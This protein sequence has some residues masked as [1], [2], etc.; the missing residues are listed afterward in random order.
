MKHIYNKILLVAFIA[1][2]AVVMTS[3]GIY[4][5]FKPKNDAQIDSIKTPSYT[6]IFKDEKLVALIDTALA[7][8]LDLKIAHE[9]VAQAEAILLGAKLAYI[10]SIYV[11]PSG[12]YGKSYGSM[13]AG[14]MSYGF[15]SASW[16]IDIFGRLTNKLRIAKASKKEQEDYVQAAKVELVSAVATTYYT[17]QMLDAQLLT[18]EEAIKNRAQSVEIMKSMKVAGMTDEAAVSQFEAS[19]Y[20]S[21]AQGKA[22]TLSKIKAEN[23]MRLL[24]CKQG[25]DID[26]SSLLETAQNDSE[27]ESIQL[28]ATRVRPDVKAAEH[29]LEQAFYSMNLARANCCPSITLTGS[30]GWSGGLIYNAVASLVQPLFNSGRNIAEVQSAKHALQAAEYSY[31]K[32]L[33]VAATEVNDAIA[34]KKLYKAQ[35]PDYDLQV[36]S[37]ASAYDA[38][39][40]KMRLGYGTYLEVLTA[41][42]DLL[43]A[44]MLQIQNYAST[45]NAGVD[46]YKALGGG[47]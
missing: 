39:F 29:Q 28:E 40:T 42:K 32:S 7:N 34:A 4:G 20:S 24:L 27:I 18:T 12:T 37:L 13:S 10:P 3:C 14:M 35:Q 17:I 21:V 2:A 30:I 36:L 43:S 11:S 22:L 25:Y 1:S 26:R 16:E 5:K 47:K 31:S 19:F 15:G 41:Q 9:N 8:N 44:Q 38:T 23:A 33:I 46:L 45:L 6:D